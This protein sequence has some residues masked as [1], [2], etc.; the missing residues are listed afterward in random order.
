MRQTWKANVVGESLALV[1]KYDTMRARTGKEH[2]AIIKGAKYLLNKWSKITSLV[3]INMQK[4]C[5]YQENT[6]E[7]KLIL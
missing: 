2:D 4:R 1:C 3:A 5:I 7:L 6:A